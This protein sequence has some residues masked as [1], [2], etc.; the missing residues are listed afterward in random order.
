MRYISTSKVR[1]QRHTLHSAAAVHTVLSYTQLLLLP[2]LK[3]ARALLLVFL[4]VQLSCENKLSA[5]YATQH[6][7]S[8]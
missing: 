3:H 4:L 1:R 7:L 5:Q 6:L 8:T 2:L